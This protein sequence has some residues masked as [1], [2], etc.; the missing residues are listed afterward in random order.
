MERGTVS[1]ATL[2]TCR[3]ISVDDVYEKLMVRC[4]GT[5]RLWQTFGLR[6]IW[7]MKCLIVK[8]I[9]RDCLVRPWQPFK[10]FIL[11]KKKKTKNFDP[12]L[13]GKKARCNASSSMKTGYV[14]IRL[15]CNFMT[16]Q[17]S[18]LSVAWTYSLTRSYWISSGSCP[19]IYWPNIK[20]FGTW[21]LH[22]KTFRCEGF[23]FKWPNSKTYLLG[24][25]WSPV[26][27]ENLWATAIFRTVHAMRTC[28]FIYR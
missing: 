7:N 11:S 4:L 20:M 23:F 5:N 26:G 12:F 17:L 14:T 28:R 10:N 15:L 24:G 9:A 13:Q 21:T 18:W 1:G 22:C 2:E 3:R 25:Q 19:A 27:V 8:M 16:M 6:Y